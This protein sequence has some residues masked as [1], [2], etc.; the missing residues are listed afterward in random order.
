MK[1]LWQLMLILILSVLGE[2]LHFLIPLPIPASIYGLVLL[3][4]A[5]WSGILK[6]EQIKDVANYLLEIMPIIFVPAL[7]GVIVIG[8]QILAFIIPILLAITVVT[9][10]VMAVTGKTAQAWLS[11]QKNKEGKQ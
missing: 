2:V 5:L 9:A 8:E 10:L 4:L 3:F 6:L 1:Y 7:V 11:H